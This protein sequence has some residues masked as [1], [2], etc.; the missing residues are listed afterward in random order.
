MKQR[1]RFALRHPADAASR[2]LQ[3]QSSAC[4]VTTRVFAYEARRATL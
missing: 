4:T 2:A 3:N 1:Q